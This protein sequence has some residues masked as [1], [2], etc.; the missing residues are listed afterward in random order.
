LQGK[1]Y[2]QN[3]LQADI[4]VQPLLLFYGVSSLSRTL[5]LLLKLDGGEET[6][7]QAHGL[8]CYGWSG[9][10]T[11]DVRRGLKALGTLEVKSGNGMFTD[12]MN[13]IGN[14][15]DLHVQSGKVDWSVSYPISLPVRL[16]II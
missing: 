2:Y 9:V 7:T 13:A 12:L 16:I 5:T 6:L 8:N 4:S 14:R 10:L 11:T 1:E 15:F 3:A